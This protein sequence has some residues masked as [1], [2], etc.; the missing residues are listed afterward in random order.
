MATQQSDPTADAEATGEDAR[1]WRVTVS[2]DGEI[3]GYQ[4]V[5]W[6][7]INAAL[8]EFA[9]ISPADWVIEAQP[10]VP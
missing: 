8:D 2:R 7:D 4:D 10:V 5:A 3:I 9:S 6:P 1:M